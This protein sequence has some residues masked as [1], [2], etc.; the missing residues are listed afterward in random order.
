[1]SVFDIFTGKKDVDESQSVVGALDEGINNLQNT[2][3]GMPNFTPDPS[4]ARQIRYAQNNLVDAGDGTFYSPEKAIAQ[5]KLES[6]GALKQT[7]TDEYER[8]RQNPL[9]NIMDIGADVFRNT[10]GL[11]PNMLT[12]GTAMTFDPSKSANSNYKSS[13]AELIGNQRAALEGLISARKTRAQAFAGGIG[14]NVSVPFTGEDG[15]QYNFVDDGFGSLTAQPVLD[16]DGNLVRKMKQQLVNI[17]GVPT[18]VDVNSPTDGGRS[19]T[20]IGTVAGNEGKVANER[21]IATVTGTAQGEAMVNLDGAREAANSFSSLLD[22]LHDHVGLSDVVGTQF[23]SIY[24]MKAGSNAADFNAFKEQV[25]GKLF[26]QARESLKGA[27][28]VTD[29]EGIKGEQA[30]GRL[31]ASQSVP[32]FKQAVRDI[33]DMIQK[34]LKKIESKAGGVYETPNRNRY[35]IVED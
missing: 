5:Q 4:D 15:F 7:V 26:L 11:V 35:E 10:V 31:Q 32:A 14:K 1:M 13:M 27:G 33:Q 3:M 21:A 30:M 25:T 19:L 16:K 9:F 2:I 34:D 28:S 6:I 24:A 22:Q 23:G 20:D 17:A 29:F 12:G 18:L 8:K